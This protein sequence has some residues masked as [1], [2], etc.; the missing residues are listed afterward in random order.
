MKNTK[1]FKVV[2]AG[3]AGQGIKSAGLTLSKLATRSGFNIYNYIEYPSIIR[4]GHNV[5]QINI[6]KS[7]IRGPSKNI[8][9]LIALNQE[10]IF[11]HR[12]EIVDGGYVLYDSSL[13][14]GVD[15]IK[16]TVNSLPVPLND[17]A[18]QSGGSDLLANTVA[19]GVLIGLTAGDLNILQ[20]LAREEYGDKKA[21]LESNIKAIE[22]GYNYAKDNF[23]KH[24]EEIYC[25]SPLAD[26]PQDMMVLHGDD[27]TALGAIAA[28]LQ[29]AAIYPMSPI[30]NILHTL[31]K[32]QQQFKFVYKQ[33]EDEISAI[34]MAIGASY[35]GARS[36]TATS[37]GGFCLMTEGYGLAG[38]TETPL[39]IVLGM[40]GGPATGLPTWTSQGDLQFV[41][42]AH[43]DEFPRIVLAAGDVADAFYMTM[44]AFH[45][46]D[47]YQTPVVVM[48]DKSICDHEQNIK[49][50][51]TAGYKVDRSKLT[52]DTVTD[53]KRYALSD[54]GVSPRTV[55]GKGNFFI[56]N[57]DE[58]TEVGFSTEEADQRIQQMNKRMQKLETCA[59]Q[60]M[61]EPTVY[62]PKNADLTIVGWGS[63]SG[64]IL[65]AIQEFDN[66]NYL[67]IGW[68]NPFPTKFV[69]EFLNKAKKTMII[70]GNY[71]GQLANLIRE[72][73][74]YTFENKI[75]KY[76][77]RPFY[78]EE[79]IEHIKLALGGNK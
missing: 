1:V 38:I 48:I 7:P 4:G 52:F 61:P 10:S 16:P 57:S 55:P 62:G 41:L 44:E 27:A 13:K 73:T 72:K 33:P 71:T 50:F 14:F 21:L 39:V 35:A 17:L 56:S 47:K 28:G 60:D 51:D 32:Y 49:L 75:L 3:Q 2:I 64:S 42:H 67:H 25:L 26:A 29:F 24:C 65:S 53:F 78:I 70:E 59:L 22:L 23:A 8:D 34:N 37:G 74:G 46:A 30:S 69:S 66:V 18:K 40:R 79:V 6:S 58:H 36:M 76:D 19:L 68:M 12:D 54:D 31:A 43:Q 20:E 9:F 15:K 77:G 11:K 45:L 63:T 5:M